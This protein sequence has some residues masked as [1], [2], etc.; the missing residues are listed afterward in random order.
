M[1]ANPSLLARMNPM[2]Q[3]QDFFLSEQRPRF[4]DPLG[5]WI[6]LGTSNQL[7]EGG[8]AH[9]LCIGNAEGREKP[10]LLAF[11][12]CLAVFQGNRIRVLT[13]LIASGKQ[14]GI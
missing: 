4:K 8:L 11:Q 3:M 12:L 2:K 9:C 10:L 13:I 14:G 5:L 1:K 7:F 6:L